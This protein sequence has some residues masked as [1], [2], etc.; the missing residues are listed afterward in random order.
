MNALL[1]PSN[2]G[3]LYLSGILK[4]PCY[5][6]SLKTIIYSSLAFVQN[7]WQASWTKNSNKK[8]HKIWL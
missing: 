1:N 4:K 3:I 6:S 7:F 5:L 8:K 2:R